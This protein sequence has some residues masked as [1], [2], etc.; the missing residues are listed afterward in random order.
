M[1]PETFIYL[2]IAAALSVLFALVS[3]ASNNQWSQGRATGEKLLPALATDA[4][5][6][7]AIEVRQGEATVTLEKTGG[8]WVVKDRGGYPVD[9]AKV[10]TLLVALVE[11]E[12]TE[13]KTKR[14]DR[15]AVLE[16]EDPADK[17]A[18]SRLVRLKDGRG[19]TIGEVVIGK[20]RQEALGT[21][22]PGT[23]VRKPG[24]P[25][26]WLANTE[27]HASLSTKDWMK[28]NV[29]SLDAGKISRISIEIP[30]E[31]ALKIE[32]ETPPPAKDAKDAKDGKDAKEAAD[33]PPPGKLRFVGFPPEGKKLKDAGAAESLARAAASI[34]MED[35]R[36][37]AGPPAGAGVSV[38]KIE[39]AEGPTTTLHLRKDGDSHWLAVTATGEGEAKKAAD[40]IVRRT[41]G[42]EYKLP[43]A[44]ADAILKK[45]NDLLEAPAPG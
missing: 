31:Q 12:L 1:K 17:A 8:S 34:D 2:A 39:T 20:Q 35:V 14:P 5:Q 44:K 16:L 3:Y 19:G 42:W 26:A 27:L 13:P 21:G 28:T 10:R 45:R 9:F 38:V 37:L 29:L 33:P 6:I 36:K 7:A 24:D 43:A 41:Q 11:A 22:K 18:K 30:G 25:Q 23:Y 4:G 32:R 15:Y 40:E